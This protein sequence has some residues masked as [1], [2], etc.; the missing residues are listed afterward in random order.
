M[1]IPFVRAG[2]RRRC[3]KSV[4]KHQT[5]ALGKFIFHINSKEL[6]MNAH[7]SDYVRRLKGKPV[8]GTVTARPDAVLNQPRSGET[9]RAAA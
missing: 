3:L 4:I 1:L 7:A 6:L 9:A 5:I 8:P 2:A